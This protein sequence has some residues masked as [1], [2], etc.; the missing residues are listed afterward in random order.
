MSRR[1]ADEL[2]GRKLP[3]HQHGHNDPELEHQIGGGELECHGGDEVAALAEDRARES[4]RRI[5]AGRAGSAER[6]RD[7][8]RARRSI[9]QQAAHLAFGDDGL[10]HA[11]ERKAQDQRPEDLPTHG[12]GHR[13]RIK[14]RLSHGLEQFQIECAYPA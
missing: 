9:G 13:K 8:D 14:E 7:Q 6:A 10:D 4:H 11:R 5:G 2:G 1:A 12:E 3:S